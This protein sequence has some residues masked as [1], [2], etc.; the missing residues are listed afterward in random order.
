M[1]ITLHRRRDSAGMMKGMGLEMARLSCIC[2]DGPDVIT[3]V[4]K[5]GRGR[6]KSP[7]Q[8]DVVGERLT[9]SLLALKR[10]GARSQG[11]QA[12]GR[13]KEMTSSQEPP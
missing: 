8:R 13:G 1:T 9:Q 7:C 10:G 11:M 12:A 5:S 2:S 4:L 6:Q 3:R